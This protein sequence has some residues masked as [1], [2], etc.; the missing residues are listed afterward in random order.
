[1]LRLIVRR[2]VLVFFTVVI[3]PAAILLFDSFSQTQRLAAV[4]TLA[5]AAGENDSGTD[6]V[7]SMTPSN[8][9]APIQSVTQTQ[10]QEADRIGG[11]VYFCT[12]E[13]PWSDGMYGT[14]T[15]RDYSC[16]PT[17]M[18]MVISTLS[19]A[20]VTP[21]EMCEWSVDH[22]FWR[23]GGGT[24]TAFMRAAPKA[25]GLSCEEK[26]WS[27]DVIKEEIENGK[28]ILF[29]VG[30]GAFTN[31]SHYL[32]LRGIAE[33][34]S[35]LLC[36]SYSRAFSEKSWSFL[37]ITQQLQRPLIWVIGKEDT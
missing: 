2:A 11:V 13:K 6:A 24:Y 36:D 28:L 32:M 9:A 31:G 22:G 14:D 16:G 27:Y 34:G 21:V 29:T 18:A 25:F 3:I 30:R 8:G 15:L 35:L 17:T 4:Q 37:E 26:Y 7:P 10:Q 5:A 20:Y 33:D 19:N 23:P 12:R 1:M